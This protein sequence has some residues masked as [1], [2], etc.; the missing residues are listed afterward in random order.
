M[1][2]RYLATLFGTACLVFGMIAFTAYMRIIMY[3]QTLDAGLENPPHRPH[4]G[5]KLRAYRDFCK[6]RGKKPWLLTAFAVGAI[7]AVLAWLPMPWFFF[8]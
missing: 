8:R 5:D 4:I 1:N 6:D 3:L 7:G 2:H